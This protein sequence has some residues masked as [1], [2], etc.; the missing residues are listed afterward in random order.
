MMMLYLALS[1][2]FKTHYVLDIQC[3]GY[4]SVFPILQSPQNAEGKSKESQK[5]QEG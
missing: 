1:D 3:N 2:K 4:T 5:R